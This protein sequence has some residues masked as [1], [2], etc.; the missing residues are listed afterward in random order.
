MSN[1]V[2]VSGSRYVKFDALTLYGVLNIPMKK[3]STRQHI[4]VPFDRKFRDLQRKETL[5]TN[6]QMPKMTFAAWLVEFDPAEVESVPTGTP[7]TRI[8]T[9]VN[10]P[11]YHG[12]I[13]VIIPG[14]FPAIAIRTFVSKEPYNGSR[15]AVTLM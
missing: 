3:A 14:H 4:N 9:H 2:A 11:Q 15:F 5:T 7:K 6:K 8:W 10:G 13:D 1:I 12:D